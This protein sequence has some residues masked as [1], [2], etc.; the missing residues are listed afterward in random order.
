M[1]AFR[2]TIST[3]FGALGIVFLLG[4]LVIASANDSSAEVVVL[5]PP[6]G[7]VSVV[8]A[9]MMTPQSGPSA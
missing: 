5:L 7:L 3:A 1:L 9:G 2:R 4:G 8:I 6:I